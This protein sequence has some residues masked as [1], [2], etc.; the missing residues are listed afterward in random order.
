[1]FALGTTIYLLFATMYNTK[2][3]LE[4]ILLKAHHGGAQEEGHEE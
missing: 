2:E 4:H 1:V 3:S